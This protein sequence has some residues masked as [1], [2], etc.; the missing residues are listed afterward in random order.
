MAKLLFAKQK[1]LLKASGYEEQRL[2][3]HLWGKHSEIGKHCAIL[4]TQLASPV[5]LFHTPQSTRYF[6]DFG[7]SIFKAFRKYMG[8]SSSYCVTNVRTLAVKSSPGG[9]K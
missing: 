6:R 5:V 1:S 8:A 3:G 2:I 4:R 9:L 7:Y